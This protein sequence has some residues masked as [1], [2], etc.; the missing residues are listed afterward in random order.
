MGVKTKID[1][2]DSSWNPVTGCN[3]GC[4]YC[5]AR[6][7]ARRFSGCGY[8]LC[9]LDFLGYDIAELDA[10]YIWTD[11]YQKE[12]RIMYPA[13]FKPTLHRYRL[14]EPRRWKSP[15]N[16]FVSSMG[17]LF[18]QWVPEEWL[19]EVFGACAAAPQHR[20]LFLTK[21]PNRYSTLALKGLLPKL[22]NYWYGTTGTTDDV[23]YWRSDAYNTFLSIEP[24]MGEYKTMGISYPLRWVIVGAMTGPQAEKHPVKREWI[25]SILNHCARWGRP[26]FMKES[27]RELM[28][29]KFNQEFPWR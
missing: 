5:Y 11:E 6:R 23:Y 16:I 18:G 26:L 7:I 28:G 2:V 10:P 12:H 3:H 14:D 13:D 17:D 9:G 25:E 1:W 15:R 29:E 8:E 24:I 22:D 19:K 20:Y 4:E 21:N 27:L